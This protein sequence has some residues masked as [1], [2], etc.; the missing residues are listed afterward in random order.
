MKLF[1]HIS[2]YWQTFSG[3][4]F[5]QEFIWASRLWIFSNLVQKQSYSNLCRPNVAQLVF[6]KDIR[7]SF[8]TLRTLY[9]I[10]LAQTEILND[11]HPGRLWL[12]EKYSSTGLTEIRYYQGIITTGNL[13][14]WPGWIPWKIP[15]GARAPLAPPPNTSM[16]AEIE[17]HF[18]QMQEGPLVDE[19]DGD[20]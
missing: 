13:K 3:R 7:A 5:L 18:V 17:E 16:T 6:L 15:G 14:T 19:N 12:I 2:N 11:V 8:G 10:I 20:N 9:K 4:R 1:S